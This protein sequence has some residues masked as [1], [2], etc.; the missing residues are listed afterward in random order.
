MYGSE[1]QPSIGYISGIKIARSNFERIT[2]AQAA[3]TNIVDYSTA[4]LSSNFELTKFRAK[5]RQKIT[6]I[7][8][9]T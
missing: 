9:T 3:M 5:K 6:E 8:F 2:D 4:K 1:R 7:C